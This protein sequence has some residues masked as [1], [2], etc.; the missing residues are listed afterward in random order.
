MWGMASAV[1]QLS[2]C[3]P[4]ALAVPSVDGSAK[5]EMDTEQGGRRIGARV[6]AEFGDD[7]NRYADDS[8][9]WVS[10]GREKLS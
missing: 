4:R 9:P 5:G 1:T 7:P 8:S 10:S 6:L 3:N 2:V